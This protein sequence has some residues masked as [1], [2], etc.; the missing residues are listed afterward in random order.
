M[1]TIQRITALLASC[2]MAAAGCNKSYVDRLAAIER[3]ACACQSARC[4]NDTFGKYLAVAE[5]YRKNRPHLT[6]EDQER[7]GK[8]NY[9]LIRCL[10]DSNLDP[11]KYHQEMNKL[12]EKYGKKTP[13]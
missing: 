6:R 5:D 8:I 10:L 12:Q 7:M 11:G 4:A 13:R 1:K 2:L 3:E 9:K